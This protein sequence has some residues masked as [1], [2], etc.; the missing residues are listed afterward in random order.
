MLDSEHY[1]NTGVRKTTST[2]KPV[3]QKTNTIWLDDEHLGETSTQ[4]QFKT[5][6]QTL[7]QK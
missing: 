3:I 5:D 7:R 1:V 6:V 2:L 4:W